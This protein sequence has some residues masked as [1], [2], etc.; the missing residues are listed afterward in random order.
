MI[1][2]M[3]IFSSGL[4]GVVSHKAL[5]QLAPTARK[6]HYKQPLLRVMGNGKSLLFFL[7]I[8][9]TKIKRE[10]WLLL[11]LAKALLCHPKVLLLRQE[12]A[13]MG[14]H[15]HMLM[16]KQHTAQTTTNNINEK[17][18]VATVM[19]IPLPL[20][21]PVPN[22]SPHVLPSGVPVVAAAVVVA[23]V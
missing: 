23:A 11:L 6:F 9:S 18:E 12:K 7:L 15:H 5:M 10:S 19:Q 14:K 1:L 3:M 20:V 21:L 22:L 2:T 4:V 13:I 17:T 16:K 8:A